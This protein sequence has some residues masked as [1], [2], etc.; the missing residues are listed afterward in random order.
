MRRI[1]SITVAQAITVTTVER[2]DAVDMTSRR[3]MDA[4]PMPYR[5]RII[6]ENSTNKAVLKTKNSVSQPQ[7]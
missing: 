6:T 3:H 1:A 5:H 7:Q 4:V 2:H